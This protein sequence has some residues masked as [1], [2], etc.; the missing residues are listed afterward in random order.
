MPKVNVSVKISALYSQIHPADPEGAI[1]H[2]K[3]RLRP[4]FRR[5]KELGV[6]INLDME[7]YGLKNLTLS[8]VREPAG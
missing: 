4:L 3:E 6:F 8:P 5:A 2:L 1:A 7:N